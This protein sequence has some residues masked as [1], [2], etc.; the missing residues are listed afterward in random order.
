MS[1]QY[2][3]QNQ[4]STK[5][6]CPVK[7]KDGLLTQTAGA[8]KGT[9]TRHFFYNRATVTSKGGQYYMLVP[10]TPAPDRVGVIDDGTE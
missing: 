2:G 8:A 9:N 3:Y 4:M 7:T 1:P 5:L 6:A 10:N